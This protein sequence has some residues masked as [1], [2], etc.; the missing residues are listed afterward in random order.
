MVESSRKPG[1]DDWNKPICELT[2]MDNLAEEIEKSKL[3]EYRSVIGSNIFSDSK[4]IYILTIYHQKDSEDK[5]FGVEA[6]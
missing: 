1:V 2:N 6:Y 3:N 5:H 4:Y